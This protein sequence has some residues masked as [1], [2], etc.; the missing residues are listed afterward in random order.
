[1][2]V[3]WFTCNGWMMFYRLVKDSI[4]NFILLNAYRHP[5]L[6]VWRVLEAAS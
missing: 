5:N 6:C 2:F 4:V 1:M 3:P